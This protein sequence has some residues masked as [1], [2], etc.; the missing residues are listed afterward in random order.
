MPQAKTKAVREDAIWTTQDAKRFKK[1]AADFT[2]RHA[3]TPEAAREYLQKLGTHTASG[4][5]TRNYGG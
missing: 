2:K 4:K 3:S 5:L 1:Q